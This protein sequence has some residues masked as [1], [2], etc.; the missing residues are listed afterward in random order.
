MS[1][2]FEAGLRDLYTAAE[3]AH[4]AEPALAVDVM[5]ARTRRRRRLRGAA[6]TMATAAAVVGVAVAGTAVVRNL[7][8]TSAPP[9]DGPSAT[10]QTEQT[11]REPAPPTVTGTVTDPT[12]GTALADLARVPVEVGVTLEM[13]LDAGALTAGELTGWLGTVTGGDVG[14]GGEGFM[15]EIPAG[16]GFV[17]TRDGVVVGTTLATLTSAPPV[18]GDPRSHDARI[19][20]VSCAG[21][22]LA[23]G[24]YDLV[25]FLPSTLGL[26]TDEEVAAVL[27]SD[28]VAFT[29][30]EAAELLPA[31]AHYVPDGGSAVPPTDPTA[32]LPDG[33]YLAL[34]NGVDAAAGTVSADVV[35]LYFGA[36]AEEWVAANAPGTEIL[37]DYVSDDPDGPVDRTIPLGDAAVWEWCSTET[38]LTVA[39]RT[40]GVPE[41]AAA[42]TEPLDRWCTDGPAMPRWG[43]Y[44]LD[45]RDGVV[46]QVVGQFVP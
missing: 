11:T 39:Q 20:P 41:W 37:D 14:S 21:G 3:M 32:P 8:Q 18:D 5:V 6:V 35:V 38:Q 22:P 16:Y 42:P 33:D 2:Q 43:L 30:P 4:D 24:A 34:V 25:A 7:D 36:A 29:V 26:G 12:C 23:P 17:V 9:A 40:G 46:V 1:E 45:V 10:E 19:A 44:W 28:P 31:D 15:A 27:V 13:G